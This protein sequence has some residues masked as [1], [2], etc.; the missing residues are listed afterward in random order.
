MP[1]GESQTLKTL[2]INPE[3]ENSF[4][5]L[6]FC[7]RLDGR[8]AVAPPLSLLTVATMLPQDWPVRLVD[9][10]LG[11]LQA[12]DLQWADLVMFTGMLVQK[13]SLL[14]ALAAARAAGKITVVGGPYAGTLPPALWPQGCDFLVIGEGE[15]T[16]PALVKALT[17]GQSGKIIQAENRPELTTSPIPRYDLV[18]LQD[19]LIVP[20]QTSRGCPYDCEFCDITRLFG[21]T[22]RYKPPAQVL[23]ELEAIHRLGW[24]GDVFFSDDNFI[25]NRKQAREF[26]EQLIPWMNDRGEP[27][28]FCTQVSVDLG[29]D[30]EMIDLMTAAN[31]AWVFIGLESPD[32]SVLQGI[33][34]KQNIRNPLEESID[35][36]CANGLEVMGSFILGLDGEE[37]GMGQRILDFVERT[38][39]P[40]V[41]LNVMHALPGTR[42][43]DRLERQGRLKTEL[44][45]GDTLGNKALNYVP[46]RPEA[47][48]LG[49]YQ[50]LWQG[51]YRPENYLPRTYRYY[52]KM[53]PTRAAQAG[54]AGRATV[55]RK[56]QS[57][58]WK[59]T[60]RELGRLAVLLR[61]LGT[62]PG[63]GPLFWRQ[64]WGMYQSN[65]SRWIKYLRSCIK[66]ENMHRLTPFVE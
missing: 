15:N 9:L 8:R 63:S 13:R 38:S 62:R 17:E 30:L 32:D 53:R 10:N 4:W 61:L 60:L 37:K 28:C 46:L 39:L 40:V 48:I 49:E 33:N 20:V 56:K 35:N 24:R 6:D 26:L 2:L 22:P 18:N 36:I 57:K 11:P 51:L 14:T 45:T 41:A 29:Q 64:L 16:V 43:W 25:G 58:S 7:C 47:E 34:K 23:T 52:R 31:F 1:R 21:R 66:A 65:P 3:H 42:L 44:T 5:S 55:H 54:T 50:E 27:F 59:A 12:E 19:Y